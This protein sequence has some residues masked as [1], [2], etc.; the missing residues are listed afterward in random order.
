MNIKEMALLAKQHWKAHDPAGYD[1][2]VKDG[3]LESEAMG[4]A[5]L[6]RSEMDTLMTGGFMSETQAWEAAR[7]LYIINDNALKDYDPD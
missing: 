3:A 5:K 1:R 4:A 2:L 6:T 7:G